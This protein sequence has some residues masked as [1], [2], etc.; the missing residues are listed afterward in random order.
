VCN[1]IYAVFVGDRLEDLVTALRDWKQSYPIPLTAADYDALPEENSRNIEVVDGA[2]ILSPSPRR[3]HQDIAHG[4]TSALKAVVGSQLR[5]S[6]DV[7]LRLRDVPLLNR[8]PDIVA[9]DAS[10][11]DDAVLRPEHCVLV[12][13]VMSPGSVTT[14]QIDKPA[15][16]AAAGIEH[17]WRVE[18]VAVADRSLTVYRYQL[19]P[20][21]HAYAVTGIDTGALKITDP[22]ELTLD[23]ADLG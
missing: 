12:V 20:M 4:L 9:Y 19:D 7:D 1:G 8:R 5:V 15:E 16:Y 10:L 22:V 14:D 21:T 13:E 17:F 2:V 18:N 3:Y 11:P 6:M 23:L